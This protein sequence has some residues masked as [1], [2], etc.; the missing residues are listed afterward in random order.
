MAKYVYP[1]IFTKEDN[2]QYSIVFPD[3]QSCYTCG[4]DLQDGFEMA[5]DVL[6][7][8]LYELEEGKLDI[9]VPSNPKSITVN[10]DSF[11][12]L[13]ICDTLEYRKMY[14]NKAVKK[15]LTIPSWLNIQAEKANAPFSQ[16]LQEGLKE[17][18]HV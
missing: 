4:D 6:C 8:T 7:L 10:D 18:L 2:G 3:F 16:I 11:V 14:D 12:S 9:P 1:A 5:S 13:V 17:Y 15:T